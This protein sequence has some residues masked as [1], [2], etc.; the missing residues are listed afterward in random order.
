MGLVTLNETDER[1]VTITNP[2]DR[3]VT[4]D[5]IRLAFGTAIS[6]FAIVSTTPGGPADDPAKPITIP[7]KGTLTVKISATPKLENQTYVDTLKVQLSCARFALPMTVATARPYIYVGD[8]NFGT[9]VLDAQGHA[10]G[11][12]LPLTICNIGAGFITFDNPNSATKILEW[13]ESH[14][15]VSAEDI[16]RLKGHRLGPNECDTITVTFTPTTA[17]FFQTTARFWAN[18][19]DRRDTSVWTAV[20]TKPGP[21]LTGYEW[22]DRWLVPSAAINCTKDSASRY[23]AI[24]EVANSG[25]SPVRIKS[26]EMLDQDAIDGYFRFDTLDRATH[27]IP[28]DEVLP[29]GKARQKVIFMPKSERTYL[30]RVRLITDA[31]DTIFAALSGIGIESHGA[32]SGALYPRTLFGSSGATAGTQAV[33]LQ[34]L[35][36]RALTV[37]DIQIVGR[38]P[39]EF[40]IDKPKLKLPWTLQP[41]ESRTFDVEFRATSP[42]EK[43]AT[44][45]FIGDHARCDDSTNTLVG[46]TFIRGVV[47]RGFAAGDILTCETRDGAVEITNAGSDTVFVNDVKLSDPSGFF[48]MGRI[49]E[50]P[51][52]IAPGE[53]R[54]IAITFE[55]TKIGKFTASVTFEVVDKNGQPVDAVPASLT[56][57]GHILSAKAHIDRDYRGRPGSQV[58]TPV[59]LDE[60]LD[61]AHITKF[62]L[63]VLH[64]KE[65]MRLVNG[66]TDPADIKEMLKGTLVEGWDIQIVESDEQEGEYLVVVTA[67]PGK[68]LTGTGAL[69]NPK[70]QLYLGSVD[71]AKLNF[72]MLLVGK[73]CARVIPTPGLAKIDSVC[74]L[75]LRLIESTGFG[76]TLD[77][78]KPNPFNPSTDITFS[79]GLDGPTSLV[80]YDGLGRKV[81]TLVNQYMQP[82]KYQVT[83]DASGYPSG[84][85]YYRLQS[86][87]WTRSGTMMLRK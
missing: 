6:T 2:L 47:T 5:E 52:A 10:A 42:G 73:Q 84:L 37:T 75:N 64:T 40:W 70:F 82:G 25:S 32:I 38:D 45:E 3:A 78:N 79:L 67:P 33:T 60:P 83:W 72:Y 14:F 68:Y 17:G 9:F 77:Q 29:G 57:E 50:L 8:L 69:L 18:T 80:V 4:I 51:F 61:A 85:Y 15:S 81:A 36:T 54:S 66:S 39:G 59:V 19:R 53:T 27:V 1:T 65:M 76:Y 87:T 20:V 71:S 48:T 11:K 86:N 44:I 24:I 62:F 49:S 13:I 12:S 30:T 41:G 74:G 7:P 55:P 16:A 21:A 46:T 63:G 31:G 56:G 22:G 43:R 23:E 26:L 28:G 58:T 35:P 34:A